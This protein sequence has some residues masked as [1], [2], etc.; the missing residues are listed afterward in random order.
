MLLGFQGRQWGSC[1]QKAC[2]TRSSLASTALPGSW[3]PLCCLP[4]PGPCALALY[5]HRACS[6]AST[7]S[8]APDPQEDRRRKACDGNSRCQEPCWHQVLNPLLSEH[9][10]AWVLRNANKT[11]LCSKWNV[12]FFH[13]LRIIELLRIFKMNR[14]L[15]I[16]RGFIIIIPLPP[17]LESENTFYLSGHLQPRNQNSLQ[18]NHLSTPKIKFSPNDDLSP[19]TQWENQ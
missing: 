11:H 10:N 2:S 1:S 8:M 7:L 19:T 18:R 15:D 5:A 16:S 6:P 13:S 4:L 9:Q 3:W 14:I 17:V 12:S